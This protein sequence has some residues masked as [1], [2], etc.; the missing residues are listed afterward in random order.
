MR[1]C[2]RRRLPGL[3]RWTA[4]RFPC[5]R[6]PSFSERHPQEMLTPSGVGGVLESRSSKL[7]V[8]TRPYWTGY[9]L[10]H[11]RSLPRSCERLVLTW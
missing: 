9:S 8:I 3:H 7:R 11:P 4:T 10:L 2:S 5:V 1:C 6:Q